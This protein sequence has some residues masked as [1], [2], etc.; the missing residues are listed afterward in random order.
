M[1]AAEH[2]REASLADVRKLSE[3]PNNGIRH[4]G[5][6]LGRVGGPSGPVVGCAWAR[7]AGGVLGGQ[8]YRPTGK[9]VFRC[10]TTS[11]DVDTVYQ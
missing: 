8:P 2:F 1:D 5:R 9:C 11:A 6:G 7:H 3:L 10:S 4:V